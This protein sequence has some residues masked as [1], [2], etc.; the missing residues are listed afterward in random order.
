MTIQSIRKVFIGGQHRSSGF[1]I[2]EVIIAGS[3]MIVLCVGTLTVFSYAVKINRGNNLRTQALSV[4]Q[5]EVEYYRSIKFVPVGT[6]PALN[7]GT[8]ANVRQ[9][10]AADGRVFNISVIV[11]NLPAGT[12]DSA[13]RFK[14]I[15]IRADPVVAEREAWLQNLDTRV[16]IQRVRSN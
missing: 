9:R 15:D 1:T 16:T 13:C 2:P 8:Y 7:E 5:L 4:L 10:T 6:D 11:T 12:A 3:I 14:Q